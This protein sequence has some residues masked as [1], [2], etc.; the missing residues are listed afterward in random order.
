[1]SEDTHYK[2]HVDELLRALPVDPPQ[3]AAKKIYAEP[4]LPHHLM[5][6]L[7]KP[8]A[9]GEAPRTTFLVKDLLYVP[10]T[11]YHI[12]AKTVSPI[13]GR[14]SNTKELVGIMTNLL[15]DIIHG[16]PIDIHDF[17]MMTLV[18]VAQSPFDLKSY[19]PWIM[20]F[21]RSRS[22]I[23]YKADRQNHLNFLPDVEVL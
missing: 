18:T 10:R 19:A 2:A 7:M 12:L 22:P 8:L 23:H 1:M 13:K 17:F 15:F 20:R 9:E 6:V 21:I 4:E 11:V 16:T 14:H 3:E 5:Q